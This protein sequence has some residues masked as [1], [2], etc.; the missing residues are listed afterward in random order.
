MDGENSVLISIPDIQKTDNTSL[1]EWLFSIEDNLARMHHA[2][3]KGISVYWEGDACERHR[4]LEK[5]LYQSAEEA[6]NVIHPLVRKV[7]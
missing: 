6:L 1:E 4:M 5:S 7:M 2:L 3:S